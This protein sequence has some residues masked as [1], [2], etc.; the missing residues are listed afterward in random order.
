LSRKK[1]GNKTGFWVKFGKSSPE[2]RAKMLTDPEYQQLFQ[3]D[4]FGTRYF[5]FR[6]IASCPV[7]GGM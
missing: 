5:C 3:A 6:C 7:A 2:E 4:F 1:R